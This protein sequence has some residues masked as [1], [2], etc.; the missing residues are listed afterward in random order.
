MKLDP[1]SHS[2]S[3]SSTW[4]IGGLLFVT[5]LGTL[6]LEVVLTRVLSVVMW[7]HFTFAVISV[8][9][10]GIALG[11]MHCHRRYPRESAD[12]AHPGVLWG[13]ASRWLNIFGLAVAL[14]VCLMTFL[15]STPTFS[16]GGLFLLLAYFAACAGPFYASG[17]MIAAIFRF[18]PKRISILY[19]VDLLGASLGCLLA[20]PLLNI[21]GGIGSLF[22]IGLLGAVTSALASRRHPSRRRRSVAWATVIVLTL[23]LAARLFS[24]GVDVRT[25]KLTQ[26]EEHHRIL[27]SRWNSHSRLALLD[28]YDPQRE[29]QYPF[30]SWGL[31]ERFDGWLPRQLL[32]TIDGASETPI[33]E[34]KE[35][36]RVH[37]YLAW[38][39]TS[40]A[41]HLHSPQ[42]DQPGQESDGS[43]ALIIGSG[44]GRDILTALYFGFED[45]TGVELNHGIVDWVR[46]D[47]G[48]F[49][50]HVFDRPG[51]RVV[52]DDGRN[53]VRSTSER[54]DLIQISMIDTFAA[55]SAG[56]YTLAENNLYTIEAFDEYLAHLKGEGI[57]SINRFVLDQPQQTLRIVALAREAL[58]HL[59]VENPAKH[60]LVVKQDL[61]LGNNGLVLIK[62]TEFTSGEL[63]RIDR[64]C[65]SRGFVPLALPGRSLD[66]PFQDYL[67]AK[68]VESYYRDY[69]FDIRPPTD[70]RPFFFNTLK[71]GSLLNSLRLRGSV[72]EVRV[73]NFD[74]AF[75]LF[76]LL[77]LAL[78]ALG[79][80]LFLPLLRRGKTRDLLP[81]HKLAYF[82]FVGLGFIL[83][84]I[85]LIQRFNL[86]LG[87]PVYSMAVILVSILAFS[88]MGSALTRRVAD[89][90]LSRYMFVACAA[91]IVVI[92]T[93]ELLWPAFL[94]ATL[95]LSLWLRIVLS[96][97][98]LLPVGLFLG[99]PFPLGLR[100]ISLS[101]PEGVPWVW[102]VNAAAS[103]LGSIAAFTLAMAIGFRAV[104]LLGA[105]C[106]T[107]ALLTSRALR[108]GQGR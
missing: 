50:G 1:G 4:R 103:V 36:I 76:I 43:K 51:V 100:A 22:S 84:E 9:L 61:S 45:I 26:R 52:V 6:L 80:F 95:G 102:A 11:A 70:D 87:H 25:V 44:G 14:P 69:P 46:N 59:E 92:I 88:G 27:D 49:A 78:V 63:E 74:A 19:A 35:D 98:F 5:A 34:W 18:S 77:A 104:L 79:L 40:L 71:V 108:P 7:Y 86:Y 2:D 12:A 67:Q 75:I 39:L 31:S 15:V 29:Y 55:T 105:L 24:S 90:G 38:D 16:V 57:L 94:S 99:T 8:S 97:L 106:Y 89:G 60:I 21:A 33:T 32:I 83:V 81:V 65:F 23:C 47:Y 73:Y 91:L 107:L 66:N 85:V 41:Y 37:E 28:Y 17:F 54:Y 53:F 68:E 20:I 30:L 58:Q 72:E 3:P 10:L 56:A 64:V 96:M 101:R 62:R 93:Q 82:V 42:P 13:I 48:E